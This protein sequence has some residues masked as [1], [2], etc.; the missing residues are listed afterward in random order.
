MLK[1]LL[2]AMPLAFGLLLGGCS[3]GD[4]ETPAPNEKP[5][6]ITDFVVTIDELK[7][8]SVSLTVTP[9]T[10]VDLYFAFLFS[11]TK[12]QLGLTDDALL[13]SII[14][15][16]NFSDLLFSGEQ[17]F[18]YAGLIGHSHYRMLCVAY[19]DLLEQFRGGLFRSERITTPDSPAEFDV[20]VSDVT[21]LSANVS[22]VPPYEELTYYAWMEDMSEYENEFES[23][24]NLV[25]Q[26]DYAFWFWWAGS[27]SMDISEVISADLSMG[28]RDLTTDEWYTILRWD[29]EYLVYA[30]G[31]DEEGNL[32]VPMTK[33]TFRT[34]KPTPSDNTFEI[35]V[36]RMEYIDEMTDE[37]HS[38]GWDVEVTVKPSNPNDT[39]YVTITNTDW[40]DWFFSEDNTSTPSDEP[41]IQYTM[42]KNILQKYYVGSE[43]LPLFLHKGQSTLSTW[44]DRQLLLGGTKEYGAFVFGV[45]ENGATT[46]TTIL[47]FNLGEQQ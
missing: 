2:F 24:D 38:Y 39:Y 42:L 32:T 9:P 30:Y 5:T 31:C 43:A 44:E 21:G 45:G 28:S 37:G 36:S 7:D 34:K 29:T 22:I 6:V 19:D 12:A 16:E 17:T 33:R 35:E 41:Y 40:Y 25:M 8:S 3:N 14:E 26:N 23:N 10:G 13:S 27:N 4:E 20:Q 47:R 11:D 1:K 15:M 18:T 46:E